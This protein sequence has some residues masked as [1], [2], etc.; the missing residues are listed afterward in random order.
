[1]EGY[2]LHDEID[3]PKYVK[4]CLIYGHVQLMCVVV[5]GLCMA[6]SYMI[7][8]EPIILCDGYDH[9]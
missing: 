1:M 3:I 9:E 7:S 6:Y 8:S 5:Y 4:G 2:G